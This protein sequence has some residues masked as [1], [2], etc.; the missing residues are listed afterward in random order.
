[1]VAP[2]KPA[3]RPAGE[4]NHSRIWLRGN[5]VE[6]WL[7][8]LKVVDS[9]LDA[10]EAMAGIQKRW[11]IVPAVYEMLSKQ[12]KKDCPISLQNHGDAAWFRDIKIRRLNSK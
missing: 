4:F 8:G 9:S 1:M 11:S 3:A 12:P 7:N 5:R 10:P 6:H 2:S